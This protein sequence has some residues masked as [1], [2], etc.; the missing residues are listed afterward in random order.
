MK[1][2]IVL[3]VVLV[4][5]VC[6]TGVYIYSV[7]IDAVSPQ[8]TVPTATVG[9]EYV[10]S[11]YGF[12]FSLPET[13]RGYTVVKNA[14]NGEAMAQNTPQKG[15]KLLMRNPKW[16]ADFP[17]EDIPVLVFT[18]SQWE[19]Y[20]AEGFSISPAPIPATELARNNKYVFALPP[21]WNYDYS[22]GYEEADSIVKSEPLKAFNI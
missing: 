4:A 12:T 2:K 6:I 10:N 3:S 19:S 5:I 9:V 16:T 13:W 21:R 15:P 18:I 17:Y 8:N 7:K 22:K 11:E 20:V 14:W 1:N